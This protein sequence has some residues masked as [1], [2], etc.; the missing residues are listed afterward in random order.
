MQDVKSQILAF[1]HHVGNPKK[2][3]ERKAKERKWLDAAGRPTAD[4]LALIAAL[5]DQRETRST[6]RSVA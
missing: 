2:D 3:P 1:A 4:G 5:H 6:F